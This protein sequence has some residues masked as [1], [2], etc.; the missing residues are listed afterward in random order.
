MENAEQTNE[1]KPHNFLKAFLI[2]S[3]RK[4]ERDGA[5]NCLK[6]QAG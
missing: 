3:M 6:N 1:G 2:A 5:S 4:F